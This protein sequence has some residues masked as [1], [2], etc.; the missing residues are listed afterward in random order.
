M[1]YY[2]FCKILVKKSDKKLYKT[3]HKS[4]LVTLHINQL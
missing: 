3:L 1:N 2:L 4:V